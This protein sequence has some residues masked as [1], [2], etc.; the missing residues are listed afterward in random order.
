MLFRSDSDGMN[1]IVAVNVS[2]GIGTGIFANGRLLRG[3]DGMAGEF[4]HVQ[5]KAN[6]P[7]C[8]CGSTGCW[9]T[10]AS[11]RAGLR[12]Y[13]EMGGNENLQSFEALVKLALASDRTAVK[14]LE[15]M[16]VYLGQGLRMIASALA[17]NEIVIVGDITAAWQRFAPIVEAELNRNSLSKS[18]KL[19]PSA[20]GSTARL[21]SAVAL[22]M[23]DG[24]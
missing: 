5:M 16:S 10:L 18:I 13:H 23:N 15:K 8:A 11:N 1:D 19:R 4:G 6:G 22:V 20:E 12:Y 24:L 9:E 21:R 3:Q 2:E 7:P 14:A 17:P